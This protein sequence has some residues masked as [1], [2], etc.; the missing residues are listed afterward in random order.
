MAYIEAGDT[1]IDPAT[2]QDLERLFEENRI[3]GVAVFQDVKHVV[4]ATVTGG[5]ALV[6]H[7]D[8]KKR[9]AFQP[10]G[11]VDRDAALAILKTYLN[12][13]T[14]HPDF[15]WSDANLPTI[16]TRKGCF[17]A[18]AFLAVWFTMLGIGLTYS[19]R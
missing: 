4:Q 15:Q 8:H 3:F 18:A 12:D 17:G 5:S 16:Q 10:E 1:K 2:G 14:L 9:T 6:C 11:P 13:G 19:L 7:L